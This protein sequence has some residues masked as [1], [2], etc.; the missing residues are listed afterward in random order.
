M[1]ALS[2]KNVTATQFEEFGF[3]LLHALKSTV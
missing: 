3:E 1:P 2:F